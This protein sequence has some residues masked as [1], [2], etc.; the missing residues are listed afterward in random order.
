MVDEELIKTTKTKLEEDK[1]THIEKLEE[2]E[3]RKLEERR[4]LMQIEELA[5]EE[6]AFEHW[7]DMDYGG[8]RIFYL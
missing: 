8:I 1:K 6:I 5:G 4:F 2:D 7:S 3:Q